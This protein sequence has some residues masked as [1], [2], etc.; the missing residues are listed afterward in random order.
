MFDQSLQQDEK[1]SKSM[2]SMMN[3]D[4]FEKTMQPMTDLLE[5]QRS[6]LESLGEEQIQ[7]SIEIMANALEEARA[8]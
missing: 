6:M 5:L 7:L 4:A 2:Q 8:V 1:M 3:L